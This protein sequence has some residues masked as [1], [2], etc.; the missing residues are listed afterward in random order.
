[1][2][3][4]DRTAKALGRVAVLMGGRSAERQVSLASGRA[5]LEA[6]RRQ[7]V[8]AIA[9]DPAE[10]TLLAL[11]ALKPD[12][13]FIALHGPGGEDGTL[14]GAL[15]C[16]G[17]PYTGSGVLGSAL[18]MDKERTKQV[19][20][21]VGLPTPDSMLLSDHHD[22]HQVTARL[23]FPVVIKPVNEGSTLGLT[24]V[25][26][27]CALENAWT[28]S[29]RY[30]ARVMAEH[31]IEGEEY[32]VA[33]VGDEVLPSIRVEAASGFYDYD[34]KYTRN[35]TRYHLPSGLSEQDEGAIAALAR[36]AFEAVGARGWGRVDVMRDA[37]KR[38]WLL[39]IN[40][41]PGMTAGHSLV[42]QAAAFKG[43]DFDT[44][45]LRVAAMAAL[46]IS[47]VMQFP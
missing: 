21:S 17:I 16:L 46:D 4:R 20:R 14:Q 23:G 35:D 1:M 44:L 5:V 2:S 15:E 42:P 28:L 7:G 40:T 18:G 39:E 6:L 19:W 37:E 11:A 22:W 26:D 3:E 32:T 10:Q 41:S 34:A 24:I 31:F 47:Q 38:F 43:I 13:A 45:V 30:G 36:E 33:I 12:R 27:E 8:E 9:F 25:R 29:R